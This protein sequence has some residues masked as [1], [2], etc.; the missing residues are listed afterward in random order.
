MA[1]DLPNDTISPRW[2]RQIA[3][4]RE[5]AHKGDIHAQ[6]IEAV[7]PELQGRIQVNNSAGEIHFLPLGDTLSQGRLLRVRAKAR[8]TLELAHKPVHGEMST[9]VK[10][11]VVPFERGPM[12]LNEFLGAMLEGRESNPVTHSTDT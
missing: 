2:Q 12:V 1:D 4:L 7:V 8:W 9:L 3:I 6:L 10:K 5:L 11:Q